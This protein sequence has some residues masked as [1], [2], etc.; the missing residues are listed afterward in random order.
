MTIADARKLLAAA[1]PEAKIVRG[2]GRHGC[3]A[4]YP[5]GRVFYLGSGIVDAARKVGAEAIRRANGGGS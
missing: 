4:I 2:Q 5:D 3:H 1:L